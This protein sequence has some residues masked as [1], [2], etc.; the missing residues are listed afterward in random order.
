MKKALK[1]LGNFTLAAVI[2]FSM[3]SC[4]IPEDGSPQFVNNGDTDVGA[5]LMNISKESGGEWEWI[6]AAKDGSCMLFNVDETTYMPTSLYLK[7]AESEF[8]NGISFTF[9]ENGLPDIIECNGHLVYFDNYNGYTFDVA[10][11]YPDETVEYHFGIEYDINFDEWGERVASGG[12]RSVYSGARTLLDTTTGDFSDDPIGSTLDILGFLLDLGTCA[13][14]IFFVALVPGCIMSAISFFA[15]T[16]IYFLKKSLDDYEF[17]SDMG[18]YAIA[19]LNLLLDTLGCVS[20]LMELK[21]PV[22]A[23]K[24]KLE[25]W[26]DCIGAFLGAASIIYNAVKDLIK[27]FSSSGKEAEVKE[28]MKPVMGQAKVN[29][30]LN[31]GSGT[32]PAARTIETVNGNGPV[33]LPAVT[34]FSKTGYYTYGWNTS[35]K[36]PDYIPAGTE[37]IVSGN[38][39]FY[40]NWI[41]DVPNAP[42]R[43]TAVAISSSSIKVSWA[44]F[45]GAGY[46]NVYRS[47]SAS[48]AYEKLPGNVSVTSYTDKGLSIDTTYYYKVS[49]WSPGAKGNSELSAPAHATILPD[50]PIRVTATAVSSSIIK[51]SWAAFSGAELYYIYRSTS[52]SGPYEKLPG[53]VSAPITAHIDEGLS[54]NTVYYYKVSAWKPGANGE[55]GQSVAA[56]ARTQAGV[57]VNGTAPT[58]TTGSLPDGTVRT[59]YSHT[60]TATGDTP[61]TWVI[62]SGVLPAGLTLNAAVIAGTPTTAGTSNFTVI[63]ANAE[64]SD[65]KQL[66]ITIASGT[67]GGTAPAITTSS[68]PD[69]TV[70]T[71]YNHTLTVTGDTPITWNLGNGT[72]LPTGL[73]LSGTGAITGNP[74]AA[75]TFNFTVRAANATGSVTKALSITITSGGTSM[76]DAIPLT[77]NLFTDGN[78]PTSSSQ[79]WFVFTATASTQYIHAAFG[80]LSD[81]YVQ[82]YTGSGATSGSESNIYSSSTNKYVS[83]SLTEGQTYYIRVRPYSD[84]SGNYWIGFNTSTTAPLIQLPSNAIPLT[85]S[86]WANG[87]LPTSGGV[88]WFRFTATAS[89]QYIHI[90]Y[91]TLTSLRV[92]LYDS[93]G[94]A[95]EGETWLYSPVKNISRSLTPGQTYY[96]RVWPSSSGYSGTYQIGFNASIIPPGVN[97]IPI[98]S[99]QWAEGNI[100]RSDGHQWFTFIATASTQYIHTNFGAMTSLYVRVYDSSDAVVGGSETDLYGSNTYTSRSLTVGQRYYIRVRMGYYS[101]GTYRI[102]FNTSTTQ[103]PISLPPNA[104]PLTLNQ[105]TDG[106]LQGPSD[107]DWFTFT[108]TASPQRIHASFDTLNNN[109][110]AG[111]EVEVYNSNGTRVG[112][113]HLYFSTTYISQSVTAGQTY[114]IKVTSYANTGGISSGTYRIAFT[115]TTASPDEQLPPDAIPLTANQW[116]NG[117]IPASYGIQWFTFTATA[118]TQYI[119]AAFGTLS[120]LYVQVYTSSGATVGSESSRLYNYTP[121]ASQSLTSGQTYYI[122]VK[123]YS[124]NTGAYRIGFNTTAYPPDTSFIP[125]I[126]NQWADGNLPSNGQQWFTF[127]ATASTQYIHADFGTLASLYARV[128][129]SSGA[130]VGSDTMLSN[131]TMNTSRSLTS[132]QT[133]YIRAVP[134][135]G[136]SGTYRIAFN[137]SFFAPDFN[138]IPLTANIFTDGSLPTNGQQWF[139]FTATASTQ[140]IHIYLGTLTNLYVQLYTSGGA[141]SGSESSISSYSTNKYVSRSLTA[142]QTYYIMVRP[143]ASSSYSGTYQIG[144]TTS[145]TAPPIELPSNAIP[146]TVN[147]WADGNLP[148]STDVQWFTFTATA[149]TQYIHAAFDTL[150]NLYVQL[151]DSSGVT[152][153]SETELYGYGSTTYTSRS[154]TEGQ[155]YYIRVRPNS[156]YSGGTYQIGFTAS[157]VS[158]PIQLPSNAISLTVNQWANGN[159]PTSNDEQ[160]FSFTTTA[161]VQVIHVSFGTLSSSYGLYVQVYTS[162]GVTSGSETRLY[163]STT[164]TIL[165]SLTAGDTYYIRVRPSSDSG[166]YRIAF[167]ASQTAPAF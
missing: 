158:P 115:S 126:E 148:T 160:W 80:S 82:V 140:Y 66:S 149:S 28:E 155:T 24:F 12:A 157:T 93:S 25:N 101:D 73:S 118:S 89:T 135:S 1:F 151:Y 113:T 68:L 32:V 8:E 10:I 143:Y 75:G 133:Y 129:T 30:H 159:I 137:T 54:A 51:V 166:T 145:T 147:Q 60:L 20:A 130:E 74:T 132:G 71:A 164:R 22:D 26:F 96:I 109:S 103:P 21:N 38:T 127:T 131:S 150:T 99:N 134:Y 11:V 92:Q 85:E 106:N 19:G 49:A 3:L 125:L 42:A 163:S 50:V 97:P 70:G 48:G 57:P 116:A 84:Y 110:N 165:Q 39:S 5:V 55:T 105:W 79:Q 94:A 119:H 87:S 63:A 2:G 15:D 88:Q 141:A 76:D 108:A 69:G 14:A 34:G 52:A 4:P 95:V 139:V 107:Q 23:K 35:P 13:L 128:Y 41:P 104:V 16:A 36:A 31:G 152:S 111:M 17:V 167:N 77:E 120:D 47:T 44:A 18:E 37:R 46:Y 6:L 29:F 64:G 138:P 53:N 154:L 7:P 142:G 112:G 117:N 144:F 123:P 78:L 43:V 153:G 100:P 114:Y 124:S 161:S 86:Q 91:G 136:S 162:N 121:S 45:S 40:V 27:Y 102:T 9:K 61:I 90:E 83:R 67:P 122:R 146:F 98:T 72:S 56:Y 58:I 59:H 33:A 81:L 62:E 65:T 156:S